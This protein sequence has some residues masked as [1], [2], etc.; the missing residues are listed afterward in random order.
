[1]F[2]ASLSPG[3]RNGMPSGEWKIP[4]SFSATDRSPESSISAVVLK[5]HHPPMP[6]LG[7]AREQ[8]GDRGERYS[9]RKI[10]VTRSLKCSSILTGSQSAGTGGRCQLTTDPPA[11]RP[12]PRSTFTVWEPGGK[13]AA[14]NRISSESAPGCAETRCRCSIPS[15]R[16]SASPSRESDEL[17]RT[18]NRRPEASWTGAGNSSNGGRISSARGIHQVRSPWETFRKAER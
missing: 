4:L 2:L 15:A 17:L 8:N 6:C 9:L 13:P 14:G 1:M 10:R 16:I 5:S 7:M 3:V 12:F 18:R 11:S